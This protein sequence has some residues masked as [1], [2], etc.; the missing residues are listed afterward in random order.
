MPV[1]KGYGRKSYGRESLVATSLSGTLGATGLASEE[2]ELSLLGL[3]TGS[4]Q[5]LQGLLTVLRG[6]AAHNATV[7]VVLQILY[8][9]TAG[10]VVCRS[11]HNLSASTNGFYVFSH[12]SMGT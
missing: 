7:L 4:H 5:V 6:L 10:S 12:F 9:Q 1:K 3:V 8:G 2:F 11:V